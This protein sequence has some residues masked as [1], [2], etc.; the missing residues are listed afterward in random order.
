[1]PKIIIRTFGELRDLVGSRDVEF[2]VDEGRT[3]DN[4]IRLLIKKSGKVVED[5]IFDPKTKKLRSYIRVL[6][7][8]QNIETLD[9]M[10]T[11]VKDGDVISIF[12]PAGGG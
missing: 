4:V 5:W 12:P 8:G 3:I 7:N 9:G 1:M 10:K 2:Q 11:K 6:L